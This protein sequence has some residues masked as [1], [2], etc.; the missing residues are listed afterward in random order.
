MHN[1][2]AAEKTATSRGGRP[3]GHTGRG[4]W[5]RTKRKTG[6]RRWR[7]MEKIKVSSKSLTFPPS[8]LS[9]CKTYF[10]L[11]SLKNV[12]VSNG[13]SGC[14]YKEFVACKPKEFDATEPPTTKCLFK[15]AGCITD[16][17]FKN[18]S[19]KKSGE[20]KGDGRVP[21]KEGKFKG[22]NKRTR[23]GKVFATITNPVK[24][25]YT[26]SAPKYETVISTISLRRLVVEPS[27]GK[28]K[29][30]KS[31]A[32]KLLREV[33][34]VKQGK[35]DNIGRAF[36]AGSIGARQDPTSRREIQLDWLNLEKKRTRL[37][38]YTNIS[39]DYVLSSWRRRHS[40]Y[41]TP[42]QRIPRRRHTFHDGVRDHD[43]THYLEYSLS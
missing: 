12:N 21:S 20:K 7:D 2:N 36:L 22:D 9:N 32:L 5:K 26:G 43:P 30:S 28:E 6:Q 39:Q 25:E 37:Q 41:V 10:L 16:E 24:K 42:S 34:V 1:N 35:S 23:T 4:G 38:T 27:T 3:V 11:L 14:S 15:K 17:Q 31:Q 40:F 8:S 29:S 33:K 19:L 13:R 18:G